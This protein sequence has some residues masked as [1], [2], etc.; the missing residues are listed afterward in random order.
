MGASKTWVDEYIKS[1][2]RG[3]NFGELESG[4]CSRHDSEKD[5]NGL[6]ECVVADLTLTNVGCQ[7]PA[8]GVPHA[9]RADEKGRHD[10]AIASACKHSKLHTSADNKKN[11]SK[12]KHKRVEAALSVNGADST[13]N[14][15]GEPPK[16]E[17][18]HSNNGTEARHNDQYHQK[19][20]AGLDAGLAS[21]ILFETILF[22]P[23]RSII[24]EVD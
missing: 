8:E 2:S 5:G 21:V 13:S 16:S 7:Q 10:A 20:P 19:P 18:N 23:I 3:A 4:I 17:D 6:N 24:A 11:H 15:S 12:H 1:W 14:W 22:E 9:V